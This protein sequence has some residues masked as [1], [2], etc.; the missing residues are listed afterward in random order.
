MLF[1]T[2]IFGK[3]GMAVLFRVNVETARPLPLQT[4][5]RKPGVQSNFGESGQESP[6]QALY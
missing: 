6:F 5:V 1:F 4:A 2:P 3:T